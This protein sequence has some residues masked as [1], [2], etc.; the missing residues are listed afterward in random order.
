MALRETRWPALFSA[1]KYTVAAPALCLTAPRARED[2]GATGVR[3]VIVPSFFR[4]REKSHCVSLPR[5]ER[6]TVLN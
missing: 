4:L 5:Q 1:R 3:A 6:V 2:A